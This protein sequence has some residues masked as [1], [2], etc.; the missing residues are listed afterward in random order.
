[1]SYRD[2]GYLLQNVGMRAVLCDEVWRSID[3]NQKE[4]IAIS[5]Q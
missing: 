4:E 2:N 5:L 3:G 1:M